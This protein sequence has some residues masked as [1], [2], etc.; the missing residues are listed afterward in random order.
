M[1]VRAFFNT[2]LSAV[3]EKKLAVSLLTK[4]TQLSSTTW[5]FV[6]NSWLFE[7]SKHT[8]DGKFA[9]LSFA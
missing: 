9:F 4:K 5:Q 7:L 1:S 3:I 6:S 8:K 2:E